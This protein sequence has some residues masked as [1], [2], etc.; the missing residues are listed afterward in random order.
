MSY[1]L[2][3][4]A[5]VLDFRVDWGAHYLGSER[6]VDSQWTVDPIEAGGIEV[7][8]SQ[9]DDHSASVRVSGGTDGRLYQLRNAVA[10]E[11][12]QID[13]R[14]FAVRVEAQ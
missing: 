14:S 12:G 5:A 9:F 6:L 13:T 8:T 11:S 10:T 7:E 2:K 1:L 4:P 3:D